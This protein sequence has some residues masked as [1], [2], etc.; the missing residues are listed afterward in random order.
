MLFFIGYLFKENYQ[1]LINTEKKSNPLG[2]VFLVFG[3]ILYIFGAKTDYIYLFNLS[4]AFFL[5]GAVLFVYGSKI[6]LFSALPIAFFTLSIP[7][8]AIQRLIVFLQMLSTHLSSGII[9]FLGVHSRY[10]G[11]ILYVEQFRIS[12]A[13]A[14]SGLKSLYSLFFISMIYSYF[15]KTTR[16]NKLLFVVLSLPFAIVLNSLRIT[17]VGFYA[18]YNGYEGIMKF[19]DIVGIVFYFIAIGIMLLASKLIEDS[20]TAKTQK[21][22]EK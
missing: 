2:I 18:L 9:N 22:E 21:F 12:V 4:T 6:L 19:H 5:S 1:T 7:V 11:V 14:C 15:I 16:L 20:H 10:E 8:F 17:I 13:P 3:L